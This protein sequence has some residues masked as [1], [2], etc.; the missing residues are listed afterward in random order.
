[1]LLFIE[2]TS[3][4]YNKFIKEES[5]V[6]YSFEDNSTIIIKG[7]DKGSVVVARDRGKKHINNLKIGKCTKRS[8]TIQVS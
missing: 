2:I 5:D 1:M 7:T 8:Q 3:E 6:L 4:R